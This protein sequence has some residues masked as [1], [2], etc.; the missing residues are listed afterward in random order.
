MDGWETQTRTVCTNPMIRILYIHMYVRSFSRSYL[1]RSPVG[2]PFAVFAL[3]EVG[4]N[5]RHGRDNKVDRSCNGTGCVHMIGRRARE[6]PGVT[7]H[8]RLAVCS[9]SDPKG[10]G[11]AKTVFKNS[12]SRRQLTPSVSYALQHTLKR[13]ESKARIRRRSLS[14]LPAPKNYFTAQ[15]L[16]FYLSL[17][18]FDRLSAK[19]RR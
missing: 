19:L 8:V 3:A 14:F 16:C 13:Q 10:S 17:W 7:K 2:G 11:L 9:T 4:K 1:S 6:S 12:S 18:T 5:H 15:M